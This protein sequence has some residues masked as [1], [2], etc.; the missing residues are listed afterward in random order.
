M[1]NIFRSILMMSLIGM[2]PAC[3]A[4]NRGAGDIRTIDHAVAHVSTVPASK[5][6]AVHLFV[7]EKVLASESATTRP[8]VLMVHGGVSP[9]TLAFDV[10]HESYSWMN[11]LARAGFDVFAM[12]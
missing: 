10:E 9:A 7:R 8:V 3:M 6:E 2:L 4:M 1:V 12:D 11:Y 5:G